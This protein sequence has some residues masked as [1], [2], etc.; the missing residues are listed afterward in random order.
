MNRITLASVRGWLIISTS[1]LDNPF[2]T[3]GAGGSW[4]ADEINFRWGSYLVLDSDFR[5]IFLLHFDGIIT[6]PFLWTT[7]AIMA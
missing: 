6:R 1:A 3:E 7:I 5:V 2:G 4:L